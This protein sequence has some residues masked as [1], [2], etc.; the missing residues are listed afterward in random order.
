MDE[1]TYHGGDILKFAGDAI[2]A[3][4]RVEDSSHNASAQK[5][6]TSYGRR[7]STGSSTGRARKQPRSVVSNYMSLEDCA[8]TAAR[9][10]AMVVNKCADYPIYTKTVLGGQG[11]L[12]ATLNVHCG[13][14]VGKMA[15]VHV[16]N[17]HSRREYLILGDPIDQVSE[18]CDSAELGEL[19][20]SSEALQ[21]LNRGQPFKNQLQLEKNAKS[22]VIASRRSVFFSKRKKTGWGLGGRMRKTLKPNQK[23]SIP[24]DRMDMTSLKAFH[25]ILSFYVHPVVVGDEAA[26]VNNPSARDGQ[27]AQERHRAEAE[28]RS[29]FTIFIK[30]LIEAK[31]TDDHD[32]NKKTFNR[33]NDIMNIV[34]SI[35][36]NFKGH[37]RQ[38]IV[39]DKGEALLATVLFV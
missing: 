33:L 21:H 9:C 14:G 20:A 26:Q 22:K 4:W 29:V 35:L 24:F 18:A 34:T 15:G 39:D 6:T 27:V 19:R 2:F 23:F 25:E 37:L 8:N 7:R 17:E 30:P 38:Y 36:D 31:L 11:P 1:V 28:L 5:S 16:G 32:E 10:G 3:E 13:L 12:V